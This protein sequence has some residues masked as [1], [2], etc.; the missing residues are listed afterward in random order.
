MLTKAW[1]GVLAALMVSLAGPAT[2]A[3][4]V[5]DVSVTDGSD[6]DFAPFSFQQTWILPAEFTVLPIVLNPGPN[7][8]DYL[9][10]QGAAQ[11][12][13]SPMTASLLASA[14]LAGGTPTSEF[15]FF[16]E[17]PQAGSGNSDAVFLYFR[18]GV[19]PAGPV[20]TPN[21]RTEMGLFDGSLPWPVIAPLTP[22]TFAD[23]L[24][25]AGPLSWV[26]SSQWALSADPDDPREARYLLGTATFNRAASAIPEPETWAL[27]I[28]GFAV[29]GLSLRRRRR[30]VMA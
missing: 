9:Q 22:T 26:E 3:R 16:H 2:A 12:T 10:F 11:S 21:Y 1:I 24:E 7:S 19:E 20:G 5:F 4:Y 13:D 30:G 25:I 29:V 6:L 27:L 17:V 23:Y 8:S 18:R 15:A 14:G 28:A